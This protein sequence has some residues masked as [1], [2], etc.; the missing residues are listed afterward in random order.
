[1]DTRME[2]L[3]ALRKVREE[4]VEIQ[5]LDKE[6]KELDAQVYNLNH[7]SFQY[8]NQYSLEPTHNEIMLKK[9]YLAQSNK[10]KKTVAT[11]LAVLV[12]LVTVAIFAYSTYLLWNSGEIIDELE[13]KYVFWGGHWI[14]G[15][16]L[17]FLPAVLSLAA[18]SE[19]KV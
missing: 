9:T 7:A 12:T 10:K 4:L 1:M 14:I 19:D 2:D 15:L 18:G 17:T 5:R 16:I 3:A 6:I 8:L 13:Y 11:I